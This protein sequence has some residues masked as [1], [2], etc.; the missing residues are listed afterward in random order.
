MFSA[1]HM[2]S[3]FYITLLKAGDCSEK[4]EVNNRNNSNT[5]NIVY[6]LPV[7]QETASGEHT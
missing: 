4:N 7:F 1:K 3:A 6:N 2:V 5:D